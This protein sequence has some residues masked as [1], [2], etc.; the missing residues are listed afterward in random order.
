MDSETV[1]QPERTY[2]HFHRVLGSLLQEL[3]NLPSCAYW[4]SDKHQHVISGDFEHN[5]Y[6]R[7]LYRVPSL[8]PYQPRLDEL[9]LVQGQ[10]L[11]EL[12]LKRPPKALLSPLVVQGVTHVRVHETTN[13]RTTPASKADVL[14]KINSAIT[15]TKR[16]L[17]VFERQGGVHD[18][19]TQRITRELEGYK[20]ARAAVVASAE[21]NFRVRLEQRRVRPYVYL[22]DHA[23]IQ[24]DSRTHGLI[25]VGYNIQVSPPHTVRRQRSDKRQA[26][27][28]FAYGKTR[29]Y[30]ESKW[31]EAGK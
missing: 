24:A 14:T 9:A 8:E 25:L 17:S 6:A 23:P 31:Q 2:A 20:A 28:V 10:A 7:A 27:P 12:G 3:A 4:L 21:D 19:E 26:T 18:P 16:N 1:T 11:A 15:T 5:T 22:A 30:F 29:I 13:Y